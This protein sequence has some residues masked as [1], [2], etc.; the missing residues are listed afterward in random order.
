MKKI[1]PIKNTQQDLLINYL[2]EPI[3]KSAGCFKD[4]VISLFKTNTLK[5]KCIVEEKS[6]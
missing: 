4:Q 6:K 3:I 2:P 5:R 1:S